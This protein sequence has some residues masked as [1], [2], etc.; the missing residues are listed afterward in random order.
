MELLLGGEDCSPPGR[1]FLGGAKKGYKLIK[2]VQGYLNEK[3]A[4]LTYCT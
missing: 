1:A 3:A 4:F 2:L